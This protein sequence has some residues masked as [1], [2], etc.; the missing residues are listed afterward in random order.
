M[1]K[2]EQLTVSFL[3]F[4]IQLNIFNA[5]HLKPHEKFELK[6]FELQRK[7]IPEQ[8]SKKGVRCS[9]FFTDFE[10]YKFVLEKFDCTF[11]FSTKNYVLKI[12]IYKKKQVY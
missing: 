6:D 12:K 10:L 9:N 3:Y 4:K 8:G 11:P 1:K 2:K 7:E 5:K